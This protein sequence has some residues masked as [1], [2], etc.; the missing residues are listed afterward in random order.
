MYID[1]KTGKR[2]TANQPGAINVWAFRGRPVYTF[3]G[4]PGYGDETPYDLKAHDWGEFN[5]RRNG[6]QVMAY[7]DLFYDRDQ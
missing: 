3:A 5:G 1:P 2:A 7:R 6:Y 4:R